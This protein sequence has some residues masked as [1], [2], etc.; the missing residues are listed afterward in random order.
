VRVQLAGAR[1]CARTARGLR[2]LDLRRGRVIARLPRTRRDV[3]LLPA[4]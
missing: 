2:V 3:D 4:R 1:A